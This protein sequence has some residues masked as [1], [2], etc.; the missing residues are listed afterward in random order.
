MIELIGVS[1]WMLRAAYIREPDLRLYVVNSFAV[2]QQISAVASFL[3][4]FMRM[5]DCLISAESMVGIN[6]SHPKRRLALD[7]I[8]RLPLLA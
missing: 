8:A 7:F 1:D 4:I 5:Q 6:S 2:T 3:A